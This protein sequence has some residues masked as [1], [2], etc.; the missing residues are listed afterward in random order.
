MRLSALG[1]MLLVV[2]LM[3]CGTGRQLKE[4]TVAGMIRERLGREN[5]GSAVQCEVIDY[6]D[7]DRVW[8]VRCSVTSARGKVWT[9][10]S[11]NDRS[12]GIEQLPGEE[13]SFPEDSD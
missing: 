9:D 4:E 3:G 13:P 10:W 7:E 6:R 11:V 12:F 1:V 2:T 8:V 5:Q